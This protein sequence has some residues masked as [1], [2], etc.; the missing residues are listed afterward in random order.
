MDQGLQ[1][2]WRVSLFDFDYGLTPALRGKVLSF[3]IEVLG[4]LAHIEP[5][6]FRIA[7]L[8]RSSRLYGHNAERLDERSPNSSAK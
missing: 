8:K 5:Q 4:G 1:A 3:R 7:E 2:N 6:Q